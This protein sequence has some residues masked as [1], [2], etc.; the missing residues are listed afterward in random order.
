V[1]ATALTAAVTGAVFFVAAFLALDLRAGFAVVVR[2]ARGAF[3]E[4]FALPFAVFFA[5]RFL[6]PPHSIRVVAVERTSTDLLALRRATNRAP[7][8][9]R[10]IGRR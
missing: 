4:R 7:C 2:L 1:D 8:T 9:Q 3:V 6:L 10:S 5:I